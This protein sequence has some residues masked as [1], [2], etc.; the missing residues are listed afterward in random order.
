M[1]WTGIIVAAILFGVSHLPAAQQIFGVITPILFIRTIV[2]NGLLGIVFGYLFWKKGLEFAMIAH[3]IG[4]II[5][6]G[7]L[8]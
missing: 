3:A 6:H 7:F 8:G 1:Y 4:D 2:S 5:L